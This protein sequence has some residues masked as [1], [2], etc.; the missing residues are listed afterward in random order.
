MKNRNVHT[1]EVVARR[2]I[3]FCPDDRPPEVTPKRV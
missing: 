3:S 1:A 2:F